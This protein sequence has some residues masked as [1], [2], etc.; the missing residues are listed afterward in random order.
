MKQI[1]I[2]SYLGPDCSGKD[3]AMH[4]VAKLANYNVFSMPRSPIC[5]IVY[6]V[7]YNRIDQ[8]RFDANMDL[9]QNLLQLNTYFVFMYATPE[10]LMER[11]LA[12]GEKHV[13]NVK[14]FQEHIDLYRSYFRLIM[15]TFSAYV[16]RFISIDN[17]NLTVEQESQ[18]IFDKIWK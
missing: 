3:S 5:N 11:A 2:I 10:C 8:E 9:I 1:K 4:A 15:T 16:D 18:I 6:D 12:R 17:T 14:Q 7:V 13:T